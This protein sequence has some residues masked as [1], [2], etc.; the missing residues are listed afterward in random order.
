ML[1]KRIK[2]KVKANQSRNP[3]NIIKENQKE[4]TQDTSKKKSITMMT[5]TEDIGDI[6]ITNSD[7]SS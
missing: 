6:C 1:K 4:I 3:K 7:K 2:K 5:T